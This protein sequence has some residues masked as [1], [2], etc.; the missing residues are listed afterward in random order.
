M[1]RSYKKP[2]YT[3]QQG[4]S[5]QKVKRAAAR[6]LRSTP[7]D[8]IPSGKVYRKYYNSWDIRDYSFYSKDKKATRK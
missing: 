6:V 4:G 5:T 1:S 3:D 7:L 8:D 2:Y